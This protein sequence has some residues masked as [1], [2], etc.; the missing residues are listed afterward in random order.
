MCSEKYIDEGSG[1]ASTRKRCTLVGPV[2]PCHV[3]E[4]HIVP[5]LH[6]TPRHHAT[7]PRRHQH[8]ERSVHID[9]AMRNH[10]SMYL[11]TRIGSN[12]GNPQSTIMYRTQNILTHSNVGALSWCRCTWVCAVLGGCRRGDAGCCVLCI[13]F[14]ACVPLRTVCMLCSSYLCSGFFS[15]TPDTYSALCLVLHCAAPLD[16]SKSL[17]RVAQQ[18]TT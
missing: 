8:H 6:A 11:Y 1:G 12:R 3:Q 2:L 13:L 9:V 15:A 10:C 14:Y 18:H 17:T 5:A 16:V 7:S 4:V